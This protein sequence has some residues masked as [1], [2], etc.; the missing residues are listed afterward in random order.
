MN[1]QHLEDMWNCLLEESRQ[2]AGEMEDISSRA[3]DACC[4]ASRIQK[5]AS[6]FIEELADI[7]DEE[8]EAFAEKARSLL[9]QIHDALEAC[10]SIMWQARQQAPA[11]EGPEKQT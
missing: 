1:H 4:L 11:T 2:L 10:D 5:E 8:A 9:H 7:S 3:Y 6:T